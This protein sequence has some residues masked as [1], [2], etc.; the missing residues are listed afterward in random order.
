MGRKILLC[1]EE[2]F[3]HYE[4]MIRL[5]EESFHALKTKQFE[6]RSVLQQQE[7]EGNDAL[8]NAFLALKEAVMVACQHYGCDTDTIDALLPH[9]GMEEK[10]QLMECRKKALEYDQHLQQNLR[11]AMGLSKA[12]MEVT[13]QEVDAA[14]YLVGKHQ[15]N[16]GNSV[17]FNRDF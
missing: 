3:K 6:Q 5:T 17:M 4:T 1:Y 13:Q 10:E 2:L 11:N 7:E 8:T 14:I 15:S 16:G 9:V 12:M